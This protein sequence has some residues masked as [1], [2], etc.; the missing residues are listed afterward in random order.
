MIK[1][2]ILSILFSFIFVGCTNAQ[3]FEYGIMQAYNSEINAYA[4]YTEFAEKTDNKSVASIFKAVSASKALNAE[5]L[6]CLYYEISGKNLT[7]KTNAVKVG[8]D[9]DNLKSA[10]ADETYKYEKIYPRLIKLAVSAKDREDIEDIAKSIYHM[11]RVY[12]KN[13]QL[14]D[15]VMQDLNTEKTLPAVYYLCTICG[16]VEADQAPEG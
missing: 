7:A 16:Y 6:N 5:F 1:K 10:L 15:K 14:F 4:S 9:I 13:A 11:I 2:I 3:R 12:E 8:T